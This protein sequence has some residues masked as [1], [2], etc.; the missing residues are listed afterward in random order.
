MAILIGLMLLAAIA[1]YVSRPLMLHRRVTA[2]VTVIATLELERD[3]LYAQIRELDMD[4][5]TGK[6]N[7]EDYQRIRVS[8][9]GQAAE[10][11]KRID[12]L[13]AASPAAPGLIAPAA[14]VVSAATVTADDDVE[15]LI[16]ARR[17]TRAST[18]A[19]QPAGDGVEALIAARRK[20]KP[21]ALK[22]TVDHDVEAL[23]AA[24]R[25]ISATLATQPDL[26]CPNCGKPVTTGD[27]FCSKCGT[28][29]S[30][31]TAP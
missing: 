12:G 3:A 20:V 27:A 16:A 15:G 19:A 30:A 28:A 2:D 5:E 13:V 6:T 31:Q 29:L 23:I 11:L 9:V 7:E 8:L 17:K 24:R 4:H 14:P 22:S 21:A 1:Y 25:R 26:T 18:P 10:I